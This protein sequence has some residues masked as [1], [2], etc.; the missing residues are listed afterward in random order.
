MTRK[1]QPDAATIAEPSNRSRCVTTERWLAVPANAT[2]NDMTRIVRADDP[3]HIVGTIYPDDLFLAEPYQ[4]NARARL[5]AL[6]PELAEVLAEIICEVLECKAAIRDATVRK[7]RDV[8][9]RL[10]A[11]SPSPSEHP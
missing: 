7:A 8:L 9:S 2:R 5:M 1:K 3:G 11:P 6:A 4:D 10:A